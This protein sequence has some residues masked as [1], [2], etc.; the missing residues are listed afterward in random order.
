MINVPKEAAP[1]LPA[2]SFALA[3]YW[4]AVSCAARIEGFSKKAITTPKT[5]AK[6][7]VTKYQTITVPPTRPDFL[8]GRLAAPRMSE[9][10]MIG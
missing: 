2:I 9:K 8:S 4:F 5:V 10:K 6:R 7:E 1:E 3:R